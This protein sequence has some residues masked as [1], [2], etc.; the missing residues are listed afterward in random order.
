M[1][2][3]RFAFFGTG[4]LAES[5]LASLYKS[6]YIPSL[7]VTK[8]DSPQGRHMVMT[9][10]Y[11]KTWAKIKGIE[12]YQPSSLKDEGESSP[13]FRDDFDI[14][15][16]ASYG[17]IIPKR[18]LEHPKKGIL[19]VHPS[20][21]PKYRG[22]SPIEAALLNGD[23]T[24]G[25]SIM[26]LDEEMDH[27]PILL[28]NAFM[29]E[30]EH[31]AGS[32][33]V[34]TGQMGGE[35]LVQI[36]PHYLDGTLIPKEQNHT[37]AIFCKKIS[38]DLGLISL[39]DDIGEVSRKYRALTPWPGLYFFINHGGRDIRVKVTG[40]DLKTDKGTRKAED[41]ILSVTP[42]GKKE[43]DFESFRRGYLDTR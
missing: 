30:A 41:Y 25:V 36:L 27:G 42:E 24:T 33:E 9:E 15:I 39:D 32:L 43:M 17:K 1:Q 22:P 29:I 11:I 10:P 20:L 38:K 21:L 14:F 5:V 31:T 7:I 23:M 6:G 12:V 35:M 4:P 8:P 18:I 19:N 3:L 16:V 13:L 26:L 37:D 34:L 28:Q 40:I 2:P